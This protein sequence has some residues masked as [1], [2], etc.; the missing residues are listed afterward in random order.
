MH[1]DRAVAMSIFE[2]VKAMEESTGYQLILERGALAHMR[3]WI[4]RQA[5]DKFGE[6]TDKQKN[7]LNGIE[8]LDRLDRIAARVLTVANWDALLRTK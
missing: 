8:D 5:T 2:R 6:P 1:V 4:V 3:K 7:K